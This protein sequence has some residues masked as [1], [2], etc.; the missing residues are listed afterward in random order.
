MSGDIEEMTPSALAAL[1]AEL[2]ATRAELA[3]LRAA[4]AGETGALD[5]LADEEGLYD[6]AVFEAMRRLIEL[7]PAEL[8][9]A[10]PGAMI[11]AGNPNPY[12]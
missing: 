10:D 4:V 8:R 11:G 6:D 3:R 9:P 7:L 2:G 5:R 1:Q 12:C